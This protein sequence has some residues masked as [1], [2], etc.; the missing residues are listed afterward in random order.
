MPNTTMLR[1]AETTQ[2]LFKTVSYFNVL[3]HDLEAYY[4]ERF[5]IVVFT[6]KIFIHD[7]GMQSLTNLI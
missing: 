2:Q 4:E 3:R 1:D 5:I 7:R 6:L